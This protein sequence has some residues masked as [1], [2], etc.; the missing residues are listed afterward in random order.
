MA[1]LRSRE[2]P[3]RRNQRLAQPLLP[4]TTTLRVRGLVGRVLGVIGVAQAVVASV[5]IAAAWLRRRSQNQGF[6]HS[7]PPPVQVAGNTLQIYTYG[8]DLYDAMIEAIDAAQESIYLETFIWKGDE[9]G[10]RFKDHL[11]KKAREGVAVY[12]IY[13]TFGNLVVPS[14]FKAFEKPVHAIA[15]SVL[16]RPW[17]VIDPR[18]YALDH[19]KLLIIDGHT[20]FV[21]G[22]NLGQLYA[23]EWRD[24]HLRL[25]GPVVGRFAQDFASF[26]NAAC[27]PEE[28]ITR[29][30]ERRFEPLIGLWNNNAMKLSFPI[31]DMYITAIE[32]AEHCIRLTNA[33]FIPD[34][35]LLNSLL[36]ASRRGVEVQ[37]L[38]PWISNHTLAD[39]TA[40]GYFTRCLKAGIRIFTYNAMIHAKTCT[41][42][43]I[44]TTIGTANLD[45]LSSLGN[46][47]TNC[48]IYSSELAQQMEDAFECDKAYAHEITLK[49]WMARPLH[50]KCSERLLAP[51]RVLI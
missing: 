44:W 51:L 45:R 9:V 36:D 50:K 23:T 25:Q 11:I 21:G 7:L 42:D 12:I 30:Y 28:R 18:R 39:W 3:R 8:K 26:W 49:K 22:Y 14:A 32:Q 33:Y 37:V 40:R 17:H 46:F 27:L 34:R 15:F 10:Q 47:E 1:R 2:A 24:T 6:P 31:R 38:L 43:G 4:Q 20:A 35:A 13:D 29:H 5:L 16:A 19:R 48:D 41:I